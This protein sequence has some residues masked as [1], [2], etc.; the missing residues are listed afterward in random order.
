M[1]RVLRALLLLGLAV[2]FVALAL[3][4]LADVGAQVE[5]E[6]RRGRAW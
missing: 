2:T 3:V 5:E 4:V 6:V 1:G